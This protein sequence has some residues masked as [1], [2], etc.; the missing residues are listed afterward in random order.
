VALFYVAGHGIELNREDGVILLLEDFEGQAPT[1]LDAAIDTG[2]VRRSLTGPDGP[3]EQLYFVDACRVRPAAAAQFSTASAGIRLDVP[4]AAGTPDAPIYFSAAPGKN[5][6]GTACAGTFFSQALLECLNGYALGLDFDQAL[7][8]ISVASLF[9]HLGSALRRLAPPN[10]QSVTFG[11][12]S[13]NQPVHSFATPPPSTLEID[14]EP[15]TAAPFF[16]ARI[17]ANGQT[18]HAG[19]PLAPRASA[20][21]PAGLY[22]VTT[23]VFAQDARFPGPAAGVPCMTT[24]RG[25]TPAPVVVRVTP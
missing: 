24:P 5:A 13:T 22:L 9:E 20:T 25:Q 8:A 23:D 14:V 15:K 12:S 17:S 1:I 21:V 10:R 2:N 11:G 6:Y 19:L 3:L 7:P 18:F 4:T 16:T